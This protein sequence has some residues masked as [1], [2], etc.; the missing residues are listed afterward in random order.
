MNGKEKG[1]LI[2]KSTELI[3]LGM[4]KETAR[5][6]LKEL[7]D[8]GV[9]YAD[10]RIDKAIHDFVMLEARWELLEREYLALK[11]QSEAGPSD[12]I[13]RLDGDWNTPGR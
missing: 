7:V 8:Q 5:K 3:S 6:R 4:R 10:P 11:R 1:L 9:D 13:I 2:K 12:G